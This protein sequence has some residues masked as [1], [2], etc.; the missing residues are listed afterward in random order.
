MAVHPKIA[1]I[2]SNAPNFAHEFVKQ[3]RASDEVKIKPSVRQTMAIPQ[4]LSARYFKKGELKLDDFVDAAVY[5][6]YPPDQ[7]F[8]RLV[9]E[10]IL[11]GIKKKKDES[12]PKITVQV[13]TTVTSDPLQAVMAQIRREQELA[14]TIQKDKVEAGFEYLQKLRTRRSK[15]LFN[16]SLDYLQEGDIVLRGIDNDQDLKEQASQKLLEGM[17]GLSSK[18]IQNS[19]T[20]DVLDQ[21]CESDS[22]AE[23]LAGKSLRGDKD[24]AKEFAKLASRDPA[25]AAKAL[26]LMEELK[27]ESKETLKSLD[28]TLKKSLRDLSEATDYAKQLGRTPD[29]LSDLVKDAAKKFD[30]SDSMEF[31]KSIKQ[32]T[33]TDISKEILDSYN[34]QC[35]SGAR[36]NVDN[37]QLA[38]HAQNTPSWRELVDK[39]TKDTIDDAQ[40]R[41]SPSD[42]LRQKLKENATMKEKLSDSQTRRKWDEKAQHIADEAVKTSPTKTHL[43]QTV[44]DCSTMGTVPS[45]D[46]VREAGQKLG[47]TD[48]EI[49]ELL[50]PSFQVIKNLIKQGVQDFD[51]LNDLMSSANLTHNQLRELADLADS[52]GNQQALGAVA[53]QDFAAAL[54]GG[55]G[56]TGYNQRQRGYGSGGSMQNVDKDRASR[57]M[58]GLM[59][60]PA[61]NIV[62]IWYSYRDQLPDELRKRLKDIARRLLVDLG[63]RYA[64][65]TMGSSMLGGIQQS[66]TVRPFR[67]GDDIDLIDLE[68]TIDA[69]L[70]SG[71]VNFEALAADDFL[72]TETYQGHRAFFWALDKSGSMDSPEKLGM[73][74]ISVMAGLYGVQKDD[75]GVCLFDHMVHVVKEIPDHSVSVDKVAADLLEV[76]ASG[77][78]GGRASM[79]LALKN[80]EETRAKEKIFIFNTDAYLSDQHECEQLA[81]EMKQHDIKMILLAPKHQSN[82]QAAERLAKMAHGTVIDIASVDE[83]PARLLRLTNY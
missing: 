6:S 18:D 65:A 26:R 46:A 58:G 10:E 53:H 75:F 1:P 72:I 12:A 61:T 35:E 80:F 76:R 41:S 34:E 64:K 69:L 82:M 13:K 40:S 50:N 16:A 49:M 68:E 81:L 11:L 33:G 23:Q 27:S 73:L 52:M 9:A 45:Q 55:Q 15:K 71:R 31:G 74:S 62:K 17:G 14:K 21:V 48:D 8:A 32:H 63:M 78:T 25:T 3:M 2:P 44:R 24:I 30:L 5:T 77:G 19:E 29:N 28:D 22:S 83:L 57:V 59:G 60:G 43:R 51:R 36:K 7:K 67:I 38:E 20:F 47:M 56:P 66:T 54:G 39:V 4:M 42:Y 79:K 37:R 70:S